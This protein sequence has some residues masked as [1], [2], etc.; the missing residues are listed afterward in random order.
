MKA[1]FQSR[2]A[3]FLNMITLLSFSFLLLLLLSFLLLWMSLLFSSSIFSNSGSEDI[4]DS[5]RTTCDSDSDG[6]GH[7]CSAARVDSAAAVS[8]SA[9]TLLRSW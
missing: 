3:F 4:G 7:N 9:F 5:I 2:V 6:F 1:F 8:A